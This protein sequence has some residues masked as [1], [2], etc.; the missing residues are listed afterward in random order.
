M[1]RDARLRLD[2]FTGQLGRHVLQGDVDCNRNGAETTAH[3]HH[4]FGDCMPLTGGEAG[5]IVRMTLMLETRSVKGLLLDR[6]GDHAGGRASKACGYSIVDGRDHPGRVAAVEGARARGMGKRA[7]QDRQGRTENSLRLARSADAGDGH[8]N[9]RTPAALLQ[10]PRIAD[11]IET[12]GGIV[13]EGLQAFAA[14]SGPTPPGSPGVRT[15]GS[16]GIGGIAVFDHQVLA[17]QNAI[18]FFDAVILL[19]EQGRLDLVAR[20]QL[21]LGHGRRDLLAAAIAHIWRPV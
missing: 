16:I 18:L 15:S 4:H 21:G 13:V 6:A 7:V 5:E 10:K 1:I 14:I 17:Q 8:R 20:R 9:A 2:R 12:M 11:Q 3:Q 19:V